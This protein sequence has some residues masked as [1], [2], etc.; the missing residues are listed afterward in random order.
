MLDGETSCQK[1]MEQ[2]KVQRPAPVRTEALY[3]DEEW[4]ETPREQYRFQSS[5]N[6]T[7]RMACHRGRSPVHGLSDDEE[8]NV[9]TPRDQWGTISSQNEVKGK[10]S[11]TAIK[12]SKSTPRSRQRTPSPE[13]YYHPMLQR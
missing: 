6:S 4:V 5:T 12:S 8:E 11:G 7:P 10:C 9:A 3:H 1:K 13:C 2:K